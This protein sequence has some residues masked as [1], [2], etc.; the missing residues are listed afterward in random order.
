MHSLDFGARGLALWHRCT[1]TTR[2]PA[3]QK[4]DSTL[5]VLI[6]FGANALVA[7]AKTIAAVLTGSASMVAES[8]HSWADT[9]NEVFL[10]V[11]ERRSDRSR[12]EDHPRGYGKEA[13]VWSLFAAFGLFTV[14]AVVSVMHGVQQ[15]FEPERDADY[16]INYIVL[17][18]AVLLEGFSFLQALRQA[19]TAAVRRKV[20]TL[21]HVLDTSNTTLRAVFFEDAAALA[22]LVIA[23]LGVFLHQ[24]TGNAVYDAAGSI[25]VGLLLGIV[26]LV[27]I[28]R[29]RR[30]LVGQVA[31]DEIE[32]I[33]LTALLDAE[34]VE[35]VTYMHLEFVG[36]EEFYLVAAVDLVGNDRERD[37]AEDLRLVALEIEKSPYI[38]EA[39]LTLSLAGESSLPAPKTN[40][41]QASEPLA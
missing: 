5:T 30:F 4:Q 29:N 15:L 34:Q 13:Y 8:A 26:A 12:D 33:V 18:V 23:F 14:G 41:P 20:G 6:A 3:E 9:G 1:V 37:V 36:P 24:L 31:D 17:A 27:L 10:F 11:A 19:R 38:T 28:D 7:V 16:T 21:H 2:P 35:R 39:V 40:Q 32:K 22:G 25:L